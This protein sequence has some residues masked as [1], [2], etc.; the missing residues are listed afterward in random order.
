VG[1]EVEGEGAVGGDLVRFSKKH[2]LRVDILKW[3]VGSRGIG[4]KSEVFWS[5]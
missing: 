2:L 5:C 3:E 1:V 4:R